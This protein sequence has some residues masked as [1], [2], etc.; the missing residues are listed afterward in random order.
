MAALR[1]GDREESRDR[2]SAMRDAAV[3]RL[4]AMIEQRR[5]RVRPSPD[6]TPSVE[7][8]AIRKAGRRSSTA[9]DRVRDA[10]AQVAGEQL[11]RSA[12]P[13]RVK[14]GMLTVAVDD[15]TTAFQIRKVADE[16]IKGLQHHGCAVR[17]IRVS[18]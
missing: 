12:W 14:A 5:Q 10:W 3:Q 8:A 13:E 9:I 18:R 15:A 16:L 6:L 11:S 2:P 1:S 4:A 7:L 17:K